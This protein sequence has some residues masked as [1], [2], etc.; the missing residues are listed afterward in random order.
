MENNAKVET[1]LAFHALGFNM[2]RM[3]IGVENGTT[4]LQNEKVIFAGIDLLKL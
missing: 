3:F 1:I 4:L 2:K